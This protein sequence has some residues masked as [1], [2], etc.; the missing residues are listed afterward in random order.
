M[1][2]FAMISRFRH[3]LHTKP[4][5]LQGVAKRLGLLHGIDTI[6]RVHQQPVGRI[7]GVDV[8]EGR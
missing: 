8:M 1:I 6:S 3:T 7:A 4:C 5:L 2:D